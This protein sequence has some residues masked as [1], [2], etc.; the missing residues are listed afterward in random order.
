VE[1]K[2]LLQAISNESGKSVEELVEVL[3]PIKKG[4]V[5]EF[6]MQ[7]DESEKGYYLAMYNQL[8]RKVLPKPISR[9]SNKE[10]Y[11]INPQN[12]RKSTY[13]RFPCIN[14]CVKWTMGASM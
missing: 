9:T 1:Q 7:Y 14:T 6:D 12:T 10:S 13:N 3:E 4:F 8:K 11:R 5:G 2:S